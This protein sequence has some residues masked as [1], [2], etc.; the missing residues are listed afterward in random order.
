MYLRLMGVMMVNKF[1]RIY[2]RVSTDEQDLERQEKLIS[3]AKNEGYYVANVYREKAS[4]AR[5]DRPELQRMISDLQDGDIVIAERIDRIS[6]LPLDEAMAL[7]NAI[8]AKGAKLSIPGIFDLSEISTETTGITKIVLD[9][10]QELLL[11]ISLQGSRDEYEDRRRRQKEGID[12]AKKNNKYQGR[13]RNKQL[14]KMIIECRSSGMS[15]VKTAQLV[16]TSTTTVKSV[17]AKHKKDKKN[18]K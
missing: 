6:R 1:A 18:D 11:K 2:I 8:K 9:A 15:I 4:G 16:S 5:S 12:L 14:H 10:I 17:W 7:V 3:D 13:K